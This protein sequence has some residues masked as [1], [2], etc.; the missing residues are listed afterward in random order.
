MPSTCRKVH[1]HNIFMY[2]ELLKSLRPAVQFTSHCNDF[3]IFINILSSIHE[4]VY[5]YFIKISLPGNI[6]ISRYFKA[7]VQS[8]SPPPTLYILLT[9]FLSNLPEDYLY[10]RQNLT[11]IVTI[12]SQGR[13]LLH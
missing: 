1:L 12:I 13:K 2:N 5:I 4:C 11:K 9:S 7:L 10:R 6:T 8:L 3:M